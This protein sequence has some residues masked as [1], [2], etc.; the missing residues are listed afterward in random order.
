[1]MFNKYIPTP[2]NCLELQKN[3]KRTLILLA[4]SV[5]ITI[6]CSSSTTIFSQASY[7]PDTSIRN[8][9]RQKVWQEL[10][11]LTP[12]KLHSL[13]SLV[14]KSESYFGEYERIAKAKGLSPYDIS[15]IKTFSNVILEEVKENKT[16]NELEISKK[17]DSVKKQYATTK[18]DDEF[19]NEQKQEKYDSF[20]L[21]SMW[22]AQLAQSKSV[23]QDRLRFLADKFLKVQ[24]VNVQENQVSVKTPSK[25]VSSETI[26]NT[27]DIEDFILRTVTK[28][29]LNGVY[30]KNQVSVL[31]KNGMLFT[32][33]IQPL[34]TFDVQKS[35]REKPGKWDSWQKNGNTIQVNRSK[36]GK[37]VD[38]KKWHKVRPAT[39]G[40][41]L[42]GKFNTA[43]GFGGSV[44]INASTIY[45][46]NQGLFT[47]KTVQGGN[48]VWKPVFVKTNS[49]GNYKIDNYTIYLAYNNGVTESYFFGL[50][51]KDNQHFIIGENHFVPL[52][53]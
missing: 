47:W 10:K 23:K 35:K 12:T 20:I 1:M 51:P 48:T 8:Q 46:D 40:F 44:V 37:V 17:Y 4:K 11:P 18:I 9:I 29:G 16:L 14:F 19:N 50:Y 41:K 33:P 52:N 36:N 15:T 21:K 7:T 32:N 6:L 26:N 24:A 25:P 38:W 5:L 34:E 45:F 27:N 22:L 49:S 39:K 13:F 31:Y 3:V 30:I 2:F 53:N 42:Q 28:Y 43:D